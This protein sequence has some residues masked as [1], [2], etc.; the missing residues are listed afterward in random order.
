MKPPSLAASVTWVTK[1]EEWIN[2]A[3]GM[4]TSSCGKRE[5]PVLQKTEFHDGLDIAMAEGTAVAAVQSGT[6]TSVRQSETL[7]LVLEYETKS[8]FLVRYAHL[9]S[10]LVAEGETIRRGQT[11]AKSGNSGLSTGPHL[12]YSL[13]REG[14][15]IDP[16]SYVS[17]P[18]TADVEA[19][20][21]ARGE[22]MNRV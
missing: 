16:M 15:L 3:E 14:M 17:L 1:P 22:K 4:I 19:E 7:G 11:V 6:V 18:Y 12:H 9:Q 20:Y 5:N 8:G 10:V 21:A 13:Y 2:P